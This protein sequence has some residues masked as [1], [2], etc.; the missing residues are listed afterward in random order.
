MTTYITMDNETIANIN[1]SLEAMDSEIAKI[2]ETSKSSPYRMES[3][4]LTSRQLYSQK[5]PE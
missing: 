3:D 2:R 1:N 4:E 5:L